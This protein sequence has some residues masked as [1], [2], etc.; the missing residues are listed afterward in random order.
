MVALEGQL[1]YLTHILTYHE[2][3]YREH[4]RRGGVVKKLKQRKQ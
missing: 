4:L 2:K 1:A 3:D